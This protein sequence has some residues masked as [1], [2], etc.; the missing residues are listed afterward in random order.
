MDL[1]AGNKYENCFKK[2][3]VLITDAGAGTI[4]Y[5]DIEKKKEGKEKY[6]FIKPRRIFIQIFKIY[7]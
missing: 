4:S 5:S 2:Q 6:E 7:K 3:T 1:K